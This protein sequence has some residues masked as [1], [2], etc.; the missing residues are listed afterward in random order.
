MYLHLLAITAGYEI[1]PSANL[2]FSKGCLCILVKGLL[3]SWRWFGGEWGGPYFCFL[4]FYFDSYVATHLALALY[5][6]HAGNLF[7]ALTAILIFFALKLLHH[8]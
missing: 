4:E 3:L 8:T 1:G 2:S 5:H 7:D 6:T